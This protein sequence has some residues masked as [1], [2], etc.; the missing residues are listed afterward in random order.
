[1]IA[2]KKYWWALPVFLLVCWDR[3]IW[4]GL[5]Q[6]REDQ[7]ANLWMGYQFFSSFPKVGLVNSSHIYNPNGMA[8]FS[9]PFAWLPGLHFVSFALSLMQVFAV[10]VFAFV[11][12]KSALFRT[13]FIVAGLSSVSMRATGIELWNQWVLNPVHLLTVAA[14]ICSLRGSRLGLVAFWFLA[15]LNPALYMGGLLVPVSCFLF[16]CAAHIQNR[17]FKTSY[18]RPMLFISKGSVISFFSGLLFFVVVTWVPFFSLVSLD[19]MSSLST[20]SVWGRFAGA[21]DAIKYFPRYLHSFT[22]M[23]VFQN[24]WS[25]DILGD[26]SK[27]LSYG[28]LFLKVQMYL[29][30]A[31]AL[32]LLVFVYRYKKKAADF[33]RDDSLKWFLLFVYVAIPPVSSSL[34]GGPLFHN[35][36][37]PDIYIAYLPLTL[38]AWF[39]FPLI[40]KT[41][42]GNGFMMVTCCNLFA[43]ALY[44]L[45]A[46]YLTSRAHHAYRGTELFGP[47][48][49]LTNKVAAVE[50]VAKSWKAQSQDVQLPVDYDLVG[51]WTWIEDYSQMMLD[52]F[53]HPVFTVGRALDFEFSRRYGLMN[54]KEG[55][56]QR[57][58]TNGK[59]VISY[60]HEPNKLKPE[61]IAEEKYFGRLRVTIRR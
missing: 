21:Y 43:M 29:F 39:C 23:S 12:S 36:E 15:L 6:W 46:G 4:S 14:M 31:F 28:N 25:R 22:E 60:A 49:P 5:A 17:Y 18:F 56:L 19:Q 45:P 2:L 8:L 16:V 50:Y 58:I 59:Y 34:L 32:Y 40:L 53:P 10:C 38:F 37:R 42:L 35:E 57:G 27:Y 3:W 44:C 51:P 13:V 11:V 24:L 26:V 47:D 33:F 61:Q 55:Q 7:G 52:Q 9:M 1:M 54:Y 30:F 20:R 48:V 41:K